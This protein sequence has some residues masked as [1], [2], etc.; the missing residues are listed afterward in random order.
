MTLIR[1]LIAIPE[2]VHQGD[3]VLKLAEGVRAAD[4]TLGNYV[5]TP[6]LAQAFD[7]A[8]A[9]G[10]PQP[11]GDR[12]SARVE[13]GDGSGAAGLGYRLRGLRQQVE[14]GHR[15]L[16]DIERRP[17]DVPAGLSV[18][19]GPGA[20]PGGG[21]ERAATRADRAQA[22]AATAGGKKVE[23]ELARALEDKDRRVHIAD[24]AARQWTRSVVNPLRLG[25]MGETHLALENHWR[26]HFLQR[27][28]ADGDS[29]IAITVAR[30]RQWIDDPSP[31]GLPLEV[32]NLIIHAFAATTNRSFFLNNGPYP[33]TLENTP[34][35]LELREQALPADA[36]WK[37]AIRRAG[38]FFGLTVAESL[39][40]GN[41]ARLKDQLSTEAGAR[42]APLQ[43]YARGLAEKW[44]SFGKV[45]QES[46]RVNTAHGAAA[47]LL[48]MTA[49]NAEVIGALAGAAVATTEAAYGQT[50]G[51]AKAL[52]EALKAA[53][54][55][56]FSAVIAL[57]DHRKLAAQ[58]MQDRLAEILANDEH[59][60]GLK[61]ALAEQKNKALKLLTEP[62]SPVPHIAP[63]PPKPGVR[64]VREGVKSDLA[65]ADA[66]S[67]FD[68]IRTELAKDDD[69]RLSISW[70]IIRKG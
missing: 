68:E 10:R 7:S 47:L 8:L 17:R 52:D 49:P 25:N 4:A 38:L 45:G 32:Q 18:Q 31:M 42:L 63:E 12:A 37:A 39:N 14:G 34:N 50:I 23:A 36:D 44:R 28:A 55:E 66:I 40:A 60:V 53:D 13:A 54:W 26:T 67:S 62:P 11:A 2:R 56:L 33:P 1:E 22:D 70:K 58:A 61:A 15:H 57:Q 24:R 6:Q 5:V 41:V 29:G 3:F 43:D 48:G 27:Q 21:V 51:K 9:S 46:D 30:M 20:N 64:V 19:P 65:V 69:Y 59:A 16:A 35:E